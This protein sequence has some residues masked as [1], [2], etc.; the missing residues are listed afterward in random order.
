MIALK[1][2]C[3][4]YDHICRVDAVKGGQVDGNVWEE[5]SFPSPFWGSVAGAMQI[6]LAKDR[7]TEDLLNVPI[8]GLTEMK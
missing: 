3:Q 7:L 8:R 2:S 5:K 1:I 6:E 4:K